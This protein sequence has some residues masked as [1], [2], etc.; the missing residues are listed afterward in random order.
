MTSTLRPADEVV[1]VVDLR[2]ITRRYGPRRVVELRLSRAAPHS[3]RHPWKL[4]EL[5]LRTF[6]PVVPGR[7]PTYRVERWDRM[8][9]GGGNRGWAPDPALM[10]GRL[11]DELARWADRQLTLARADRR[12]DN[13]D[14]KR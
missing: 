5:E 6:A 14:G 11:P 10:T 7:P 12:A 4:R 3:G 9:N 1:E 2:I 13:E 8:P